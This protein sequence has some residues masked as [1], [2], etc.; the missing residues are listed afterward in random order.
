MEIEGLVMEA[1]VL[2][3]IR[4]F[5]QL[6]RIAVDEAEPILN[7]RDRHRAGET[8]DG[9]DRAAGIV[10]Q[11]RRLVRDIGAD[12]GNLL[13]IEDRPHDRLF[14]P[15][16]GRVVLRHPVVALLGL[17][18]GD[19][20]CVV[21][22]QDGGAVGK[23]RNNGDFGRRQDRPLRADLG[24]ERQGFLVHPPPHQR[25][26]RAGGRLIELLEIVRAHGV[27]QRE[28]RTAPSF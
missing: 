24:E 1:I 7:E 4:P 22:A 15:V 28:P 21:A 14:A 23:P 18:E 25:P 11:R 12:F 5:E 26:A 8:A 20:E 2:V 16:N 13:A 19:A 17:V 3:P 27:P 6:F 9:V 10:Q